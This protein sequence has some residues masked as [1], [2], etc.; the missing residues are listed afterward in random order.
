MIEPGPG[1]TEPTG[2]KRRGTLN[3][4]SWDREMLGARLTELGPWGPVGHE[5][6][7]WGV[8]KYR[9]AMGAMTGHGDII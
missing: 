3:Q 2:Q 7:W 6:D 5:G 4:Y 9:G 8:L 1:L